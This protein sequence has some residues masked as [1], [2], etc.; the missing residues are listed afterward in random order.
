MSI[1]N[2]RAWAWFVGGI[3]TTGV[4]VAVGCGDDAGGS[5]TSDSSAQGTSQATGGSTTPSAVGAGGNGSSA[6]G[7]GASGPSGSGAS[8][9]SGSG[10]TQG[11]GPVAV[12]AS[13]GGGSVPFD[14]DPPAEPGSIY[15]RTAVD[16]ATLQTHSMCEYRGQVALIVNI[17]SR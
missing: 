3:F 9:P 2:V 14:C 1:R 11:Q 16:Y 12:S 5:G 13:S 4:V 7:S 6:S 10:V 17:A 15:E 8:G